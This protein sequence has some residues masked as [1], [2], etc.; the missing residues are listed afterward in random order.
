[1]MCR[2][3]K[4]EEFELVVVLDPSKEDPRKRKLMQCEKCKRVI[5]FWEDE[6]TVG[7]R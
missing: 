7:V 3:C 6:S 4:G 2:K 1:M 5:A